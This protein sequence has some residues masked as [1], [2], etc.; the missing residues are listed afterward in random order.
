MARNPF[1]YG[2]VA[3]G[4]YFTNRNQELGEVIADVSSGQNIVIISPRRYGKTSLMFE[5]IRRL[6]EQKML[7][8]YLDLFRTPTKDRF[9]D[10][11]ASAVFSGLINPVERVMKNAVGFFQGLPIQPT[12]TL[13]PSGMPRF[14]FSAGQRS[15]DIDR[16]IEEL[17]ALPGNIA[18][19]RHRAVAIVFDEFQ[20]ILSIDQHLP[21]VMRA[22]FQT[23][24]DVAHVF[25]G[26]RR[27][28]MQEVFSGQNQPL[29]KMAKPIVLRPIESTAFSSYI[30]TRFSEVEHQLNQ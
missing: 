7:I 1:R 25:L 17:L 9:A 8:A 21:G 5:A 4:E 2:D 15:R 27:H 29:Y 11:L 3:T 26:S 20:E 30:R 10:L 23:Q 22:V 6:R 13:D 28:L 24:S 16:T 19:E 18:A 14:E 12:V